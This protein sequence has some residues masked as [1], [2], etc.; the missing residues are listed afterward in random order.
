LL[1]VLNE[2]ERSTMDSP[3]LRRQKEKTLG[4]RFKII[5]IP[6]RS[7][8]GLMLCQDMWHHRERFR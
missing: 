2:R 4:W 6:G 5:H 3:R 1:G 8:V 7:C